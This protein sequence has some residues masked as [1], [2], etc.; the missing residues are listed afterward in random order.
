MEGGGERGLFSGDSTPK[1]ACV[2]DT[3]WRG[4]RTA[5]TTDRSFW[6]GVAT[7]AVH[8]S[9]AG[10]SMLGYDRRVLRG[11]KHLLPYEAIFLTDGAP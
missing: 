10:E 5:D 4:G 11:R 1:T 9:I 2:Y 3:S 8:G 7:L 6:R